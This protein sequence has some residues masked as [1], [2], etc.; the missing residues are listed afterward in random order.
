MIDVGMSV[1]AT[2]H[3]RTLLDLADRIYTVHNGE[4]DLTEV[5]GDVDADA[6]FKRPDLAPDST[7]GP[8]GG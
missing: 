1:V 8:I 6:Q 2:T 7:P 3:D 5:G 4:L